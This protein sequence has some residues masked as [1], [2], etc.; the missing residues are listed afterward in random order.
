[1]QMTAVRLSSYRVLSMG[2]CTL[3]EEGKFYKSA[4]VCPARKKL[5]C[6]MHYHRSEHWIIVSGTATVVIDGQESLGSSNES[7]F[8]KN[9]LAQYRQQWQNIIAGH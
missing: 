5:G 3:L 8:V 7:V 9:G 4:V 2:S 6:Q 1:M